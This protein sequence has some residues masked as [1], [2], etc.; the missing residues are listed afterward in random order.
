M[1]PF[2]PQRQLF[3]FLG[4]IN[5]PL[6]IVTTVFLVCTISVVHSYVFLFVYFMFPLLERVLSLFILHPIRLCTLYLNKIC[7]NQQSESHDF[8]YTMTVYK[9]AYS[10]NDIIYTANKQCPCENDSFIEKDSC[11]LNR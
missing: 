11:R 10:C 4:C 1:L 3:L 8:L 9:V 2:P 7:L 6:C 5:A